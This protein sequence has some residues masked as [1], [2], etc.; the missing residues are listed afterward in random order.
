[1]GSPGGSD[2]KESACKAGD[3]GSISESGRSPEEVSGYPLP[4]PC[5][6][7]PTDKRSLVGYSLSCHRAQDTTE[8][9]TR[10]HRVEWGRGT[11]DC[12][13][14]VVTSFF[15]FTA[16]VTSNRLPERIIWAR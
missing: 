10:R 11:R 8:R 9:L 4:Y 1:M 2:G 5:L 15:C 16:S 14:D 3:L 7:R 6:E 12:Q 13:C